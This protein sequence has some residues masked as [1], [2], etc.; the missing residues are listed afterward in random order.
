MPKFELQESRV[1]AVGRPRL[2]SGNKVIMTPVRLSTEDRAKVV[3]AAAEEG[4]TIS[5]WIRRL[6][7]AAL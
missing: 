5:A 6:I 3:Q 4:I 2:E 1:R 7:H